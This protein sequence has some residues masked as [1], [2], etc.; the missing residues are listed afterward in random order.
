[1]DTINRLLKKQAPKRRRKMDA[2]M[3]DGSDDDERA[4]L[5]KPPATFVRFVHNAQGSRLGLPD[6]WLDGPVA[7]ALKDTAVPATP[8]SVWSGKMVEEV[9]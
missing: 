8:S 4:L 5:P 9:A 7:N 2:I 6:E 3:A 1:M